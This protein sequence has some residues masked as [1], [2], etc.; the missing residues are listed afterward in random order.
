MNTGDLL[1]RIK[2]IQLREYGYT[3][4]WRELRGLESNDVRVRGVIAQELRQVFPEHVE[5]LDEL[6]VKQGIKLTDF[7]QV[8]K[9]GLVMDVIGA[10]QAH[11]ANFITH[12]KSLDSASS[13]ATR[14]VTVT[15][16][17]TDQIT[18]ENNSGSTTI[19]SGNAGNGGKSGHVL[20]KGGIGF[21]TGDV[22]ISTGQ[23]MET[24]GTLKLS[25]G[26]SSSGVGGQAQMNAGSS[27][28]GNGGSF[29]VSGG[30]SLLQNGGDAKFGSGSSGTMSGGDT[31]VTSGSG[32][33]SGGSITVESG[34]SAVKGG[35]LSLLAG[36]ATSERDTLGG[37]VLIQ[38]G[39]SVDSQSGFVTIESRPGGESGAMNIMTGTSTVDASGSATLSTGSSSSGS[40]G[41]I[42][43]SVGLAVAYGEGGS[44]DM[45]AGRHRHRIHQCM[46]R[47]LLIDQEGM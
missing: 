7:H 19:S 40:S 6:I 23:A 8:D 24:A 21:L 38:S 3:D 43:L 31:V 4:N 14:S 39:S 46:A 26:A 36:D 17:H 33:E 27:E 12:Q 10:F 5:I 44:L 11:T 42:M 2:R 25:G 13:D 30:S 18:T 20:I 47:T 15:T 1:D 32:P 9:Q 41:S 29:L 35:G 45:S 22:K 16:A 37:S 28:S 34:S